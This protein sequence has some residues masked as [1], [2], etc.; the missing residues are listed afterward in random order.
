MPVLKQFTKFWHFRLHRK[1][2]R[3]CFAIQSQYAF[4]SDDQACFFSG[5][6]GWTVIWKILFCQKIKKKT[7]I[8][9]KFLWDNVAR[10]KFLYRG[11]NIFMR[12][13]EARELTWNL[14]EVL[15]TLKWNDGRK[16]WPRWVVQ[17]FLTLLSHRS[18]PS[19]KSKVLSHTSMTSE[20][21]FNFVRHLSKTF[22]IHC[23]TLGT[24][25]TWIRWNW[26]PASCQMLML[27][28]QW[29]LR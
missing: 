12:N 26:T 11:L 4:V 20:N 25:V 5:R 6:S 8:S 19:S 28:V 2:A 15:L 10:F 14:S 18:R 17:I 21:S 3:Y 24:F 23:C 9:A 22:R 1:A 16:R 29:H 13:P 7:K 27:V